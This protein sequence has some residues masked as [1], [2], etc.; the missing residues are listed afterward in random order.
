MIVWNECSRYRLLYYGAP[1]SMLGLRIVG[2]GRIDCNEAEV[3][4]DIVDGVHGVRDYALDPA[5]NRLW[6]VSLRL[7][8]Q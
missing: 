6:E 1:T 7:L 3:A 4:P 8:R 5:A 2:T